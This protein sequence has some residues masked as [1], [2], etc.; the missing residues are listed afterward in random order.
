MDAGINELFYSKNGDE[1]LNIAHFLLILWHFE[2]FSTL[3]VGMKF[4]EIGKSFQMWHSKNV[5]F[6]FTQPNI[7][8]LWYLILR[9][10]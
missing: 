3:K 1:P 9:W 10:L 6:R 7:N 2:Q 4:P 8:R 5:R